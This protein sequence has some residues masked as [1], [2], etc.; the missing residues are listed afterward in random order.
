MDLA[1]FFL[2]L[3]IK[4]IFASAISTKYNSNT[5]TPNLSQR[6]LTNTKKRSPIHI[7]CIYLNKVC[8]HFFEVTL[9][10]I[11]DNLSLIICHFFPPVF[12]KILVEDLFA[13][14]IVVKHLGII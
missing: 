7:H 3:Q 14:V 2:N 4:Q 12:K 1:I 13:G 11:F 8:M 10:E 6:Y 9:F 5:L